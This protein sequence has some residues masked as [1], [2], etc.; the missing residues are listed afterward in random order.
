MIRFL[1][2]GRGDPWS[3]LILLAKTDKTHQ[4]SA[5]VLE[6]SQKKT[7]W[8]IGPIK[9]LQ[10][11]QKSFQ[12]QVCKTTENTPCDKKWVALIYWYTP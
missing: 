11:D 1:P 8:W 7:F 6:N 5:V 12:L 4:S 3:P 9:Q 10:T 2:V